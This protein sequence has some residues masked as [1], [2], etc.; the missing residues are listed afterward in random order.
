MQCGDLV[1]RGDQQQSSEDG[2]LVPMLPMLLEW[3]YNM[4]VDE[5]L[6]GQFKIKL[7]AELDAG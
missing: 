2:E 7:K 3:H 5:E 4:Y 6:T 1:Q